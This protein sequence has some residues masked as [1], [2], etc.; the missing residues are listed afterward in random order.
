MKISILTPTRGRAQQLERFITSV[1][2]TAH[3]P[4]DI[5]ML[6]YVDSDDPQVEEY[7]LFGRVIK[8]IQ[9]IVGEP[10]SVSESWND[11]A[12]LATGDVLIM[13]NDDQVFITKA[14]EV[15]L[16][17]RVKKYK[18]DIYVAWFED[19]INGSKHC[20]FP[21]VSRKWYETL[22]YFTPGV[23]KFGYNDTWIFDIGKR[24]NR[25]CFIPEVLVEHRHFTN[26]KAPYD[27]TYA[28]NRNKSAIGNLY[29]HDSVTYEDTHLIRQKD[30]E[31]LK[32]VMI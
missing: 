17:Q 27:D 15:A 22:G 8:C 7:K 13:G 23:F 26:R 11:I 24:V 1:M 9:V 3:T 19:G 18:D 28:R 16:E 2:E 5:E 10:K 14:W 30:A 20:A 32:E 4:E 6:F 12:A 25:T 31:K 29:Q 21:I